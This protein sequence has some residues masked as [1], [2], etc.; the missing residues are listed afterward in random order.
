MAVRTCSE[1]ILISNQKLLFP[2]ILL[3]LILTG[4]QP[5]MA[6]SQKLVEIQ[7]W[8]LENHPD[9]QH[10]D[11]QSLNQMLT[12]NSDTAASLVIFDVREEAEYEVSHISNA[13][14][15]D[16]DID[17]KSFL[18]LYSTNLDNKTV[19]FYCSV[20]RRSSV[21]AE[22]VGQDLQVAGA[23]DVVNLKHGI[24]GWHNQNLPLESND[25]KTD[26]IHPFNGWWSGIIN[27]KETIRF[28]LE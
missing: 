22:K 10:I 16:P 1:L 9:V 23:G 17:K 5:S 11:N 13:I 14:R 15:I 6:E 18:E 12:G 19:V 2:L 20:G 3:I 4:I 8:I 24:F 27:R 25:V 28:E 21:L 7:Q 26:Y